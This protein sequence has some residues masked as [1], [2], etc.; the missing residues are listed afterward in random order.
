MA[1]T[2]QDEYYTV[3]RHFFDKKNVI[4]FG[5]RYYHYKKGV[6]NVASDEIIQAWI[7]TEFFKLYNE[8]LSISGVREVTSHVSGFTNEKYRNQILEVSKVKKRNVINTKSGML[9]IDTMEVVPYSMDAFQ[10]HKL[11]FNYNPEYSCGEMYKFLDSSMNFNPDELT[12]K[13][14]MQEY[15]D[16]INFIQEWFGYSLIN[17]NPYE[18]ALIMVGDGG[19]GKGVLMN[20]WKYILTKYNYSNVDIKY[21]NDGS[22]TFMTRNKL[23][24]FS[25]DLASGQQLDTGIIKSAVS[26]EEVVVNEKYKVQETVKFTAKIVIACNDLPFVKNTG[27]SVLRRFHILKFD[28]VFKDHERDINLFSKLKDESHDIFSWAVDGLIRLMD[29]GYF[30]PPIKCKKSVMEFVDNNDSVVMWMDEDGIKNNNRNSRTK[31]TALFAA[32]AE[33]C[34]LSNIHPLGKTKFYSRLE[35]MGYEKAKSGGAYY[36]DGI[37]LI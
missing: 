3:A 11:A 33:Y 25:A 32:Y 23:V 17:S 19:N 6:W 29:R 26:G 18:K 10:F 24:N 36:Y 9:N 31:T 37:S 5:D 35:K 13:D 27:N 16:T 28:R 30:V 1:M 4:V 7:K 20:I 34:R 8:P 22:Q 14:A 21:I 2:K 12:T 15:E